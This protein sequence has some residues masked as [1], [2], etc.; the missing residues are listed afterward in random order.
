[1]TRALQWVGGDSILALGYSGE[2]LNGSKFNVLNGLL[3]FK[4][5][6]SIVTKTSRPLCTVINSQYYLEIISRFGD[7]ISRVSRE[8]LESFSRNSRDYLKIISS[9]SRDDLETI[10]RFFPIKTDSLRHSR[11]PLALKMNYLFYYSIVFSDTTINNI[12]NG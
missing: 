3:L 8:F 1:M 7:A 12:A 2:N 5:Y 11:S 6:M 4:V 9:Q 10:S